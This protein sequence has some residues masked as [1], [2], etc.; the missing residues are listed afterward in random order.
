MRIMA[1][2]PTR[3]LTVGDIMSRSVL[4][5]EAGASVAEAAARMY[6]RRVGSVVVVHGNAPIGILTERDLVRFAAGAADARSAL[7]GDYMTA[8]PDTVEES[9]EVIDA[10]RRFAAHGYRHIPVVARGELVGIISMRDLVMKLRRGPAAVAHGGVG[11]SAAVEALPPVASD[12][13]STVLSLLEAG[14]ATVPAVVVPD[15]PELS[16]RALRQHVGRVADALASLGVARADR[17]AIVLGNG[18]EA[19]VAILGAAVAAAAAPLN[20]AYTEDEL[21]Y[22]L[23]DVSARALIVPRGGAEAARRAWPAGAPLIEIA[24]E[25]GGKLWLEPST[26]GP[27]R[28]TATSPGPDDVALVLHSSGTTGRPKRAALRHRNLASSARNTVATY[29]LS[30]LD[31]ALCVMPLFH[32]HGLVGC[33][34]STFASGGTVV[35]PVRFNPVGFRRIL[36]AH[37]PTW[38]TAVPTIH[39]LILARHRSQTGSSL[40]FIRS[41]SSKLHEATLLGLEEAFGVPCLE[42]Y[43]MTEASHQIASNPLPPASRVSGSVGRGIGVRIGVMDAQGQLLTVGASGEVVIQGPS[44]IDGYDD[45]PEAD[46]RSF[47]NGWFRTGDQG[48]LDLAG[49]LTLVG[50]LKE[51][52]NRAGEKIAPH[53]IDEALLK[54]PAVAEAVSFGVPHD[55][56]G[57]V[58]EAAVVLRAD[59]TEAQLLRH[60]REHLADFKIPTRLYLVESIP[61]GSTGKIQRSRMPNLLRGAP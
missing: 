23:E 50:R 17:V 60:C 42:A 53:E 58:V 36:T 25:A 35:M 1:T 7:V 18:P 13:T 26:R 21:R 43:G 12:L 39:Q 3:A 16:Y 33:T 55:T 61:K 14:R 31:T 2:T 32:I 24:V 4:T 44:V 6:A 38:Y 11:P 28:R 45:N 15:G 59:A 48:I 52:I 5:T 47:T 34:L 41:A 9:E 29:G 51:M 22:Y 37:R 46:A 57:E 40:R 20:P 8:D 30:S 49:Y 56:W 54:H 27:G 10:F 19:V